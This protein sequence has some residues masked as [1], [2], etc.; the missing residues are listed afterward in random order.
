MDIEN[1]NRSEKMIRLRSEL[2]NVEEDRLRGCAG[3]SVSEVAS[4][5]RNAINEVSGEQES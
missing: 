1:S 4:I 3:Y 5:M 2:L